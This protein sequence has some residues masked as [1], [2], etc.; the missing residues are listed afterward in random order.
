MKLSL[1][2]MLGDGKRIMG[3]AFLVG[4]LAAVSL[5]ACRKPEP[6]PTTQPQPAPVTQP[7]PTPTTQP[8]ITQPPYNDA[9]TKGVGE[10]SLKEIVTGSA[11]SLISIYGN[12]R[13][14]NVAMYILVSKNTYGKELHNASADL[15]LLSMST[16]EHTRLSYRFEGS[17]KPG[18]DM[19][20]FW[21]L[22]NNSRLEREVRHGLD[23]EYYSSHTPMHMVFIRSDEGIFQVNPSEYSILVRN[24][25]TGTFSVYRRTVNIESLYQIFKDAGAPVPN[26]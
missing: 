5:T 16:R 7:Q 13:S 18:S 15:Y 8:S 17:V 25:G 19:Q 6:T 10:G 21:V 9:S 14:E 22:G 12:P 23:E 11:D 4:A 1:E 2:K 20:P 24:T 3:T 26:R